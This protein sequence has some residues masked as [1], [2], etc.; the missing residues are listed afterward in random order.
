MK[1]SRRILN[2][3][4]RFGVRTDL[5]LG[6]GYVEEIGCDVSNTKVGD[7]VLLSFA[8]C[9]SCRDCL[10][11]HPSYCKKF[12]SLN[13]G[14]E[15]GAFRDKDG[16]EIAGSFF[17]QSSFSS[18]TVVKESSVVNVSELVRSDDELKLFAPLGCGF[19]TG[20]GT[21]TELTAANKTD[22]IA[23]LGLGGVGLTAIMV[24]SGTFSC[25]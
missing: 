23:I 10:D 5:I 13:Y 20:V 18:H 7:K 15:T 9:L 8:S 11:G 4:D 1:V 21:V 17:G 22:T 24:S 14:G 25:F 3:V 12:V 2:H 6:A 19:Q 16:T